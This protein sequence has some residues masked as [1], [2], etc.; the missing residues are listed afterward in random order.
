[1]TLR[2]YQRKDLSTLNQILKR[3]GIPL[4]QTA[5]ARGD[6]W[7]REEDKKIN[8]FFTFE[9][10]RGRIHLIHFWIA[11]EVRGGKIFFQ[12]AKAFKDLVKK[13]GVRFWTLNVPRKKTSVLNLCRRY[14][15]VREYGYQDE[16]YYFLTG[17]K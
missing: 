15:K 10:D 8:A 13:T 6:T 7:V 5:V 17:V 12:M 14:L 1:M 11:P 4:D 3:E 9:K 2:K 16:Q